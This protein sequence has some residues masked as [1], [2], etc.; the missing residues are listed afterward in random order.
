MIINKTFLLRLLSCYLGY[1]MS[2]LLVRQMYLKK[3]CLFIFPKTGLD[4]T[5]DI[6]IK[7]YL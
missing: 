4:H 6:E 2:S 1:G 5:I 3:F 7:K